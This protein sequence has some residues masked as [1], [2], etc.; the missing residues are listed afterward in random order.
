MSNENEEKETFESAYKKLD[1]IVN[2]MEKESLPL[3]EAL[4]SFEEGKKTAAQCR[5]MLEEAEL[6]L[7]DL[8]QAEQD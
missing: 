3:E 8:R 7:K 5:K 4:K 2:R 1:E 6:K